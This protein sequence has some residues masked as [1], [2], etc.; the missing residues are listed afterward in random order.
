VAL[1]GEHKIVSAVDVVVRGRE[2]LSFGVLEID[3]VTLQ[4]YDEHDLN[5][6]AG[7]AN[8]LAEA[9]PTASRAQLLCQTVAW[10]RVLVAEK[11]PL[12]A[13]RSMLT[14]KLPHRVRNNPQTRPPGEPK[15]GGGAAMVTT[16]SATS[17]KPFRGKIQ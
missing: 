7:L 5:F 15:R 10:M 2:G 8:V 12:V 3:S 17:N 11:D 16:P 4:S 9:V 14:R 1:Y 6:L 13:D